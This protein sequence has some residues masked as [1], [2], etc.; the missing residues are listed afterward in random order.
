MK[1]YEIERKG[2]IK[3]MPPDLHKYPKLEIEQG[4][5][6]TKPVLRVR[7]EN[8]NYYMTYKGKGFSVREEYNLPLTE[9][10]YRKLILKADGVVISKDR[11]NVPIENNYEDSYDLI[12]QVD[13]FHGRHEGLSM[14]EVEFD[15]LE[16]EQAF[17]PPDW[18]GAEVTENY[19][20]SNSWLSEH[21]FGGEDE[22]S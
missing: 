16:E 19:E 9:E 8:D 20:Y 3:E 18:F 13:I 22:F 15:T 14:V 12:A 21:P 5:L 2:L 6:C 7:K 4:Y 10:A 11:Y 1:N 17:I